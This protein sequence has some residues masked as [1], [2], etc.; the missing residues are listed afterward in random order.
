VTRG[1]QDAGREQERIARQ[2]E[3]DEEARLGEDDGEEADRADRVEQLLRVEHVHEAATVVVADCL[4]SAA[5]PAN[6]VASWRS[7]S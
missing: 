4:T 1:G 5:G 3:P 2:E 6:P 7:P